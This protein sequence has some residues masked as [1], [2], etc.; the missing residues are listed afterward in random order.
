MKT[1]KVIIWSIVAIALLGGGYLAYTKLLKKNN[2]QGSDDLDKEP[3]PPS[4][5][6][7]ENPNFLAIKKNLG[8]GSAFP[9]GLTVKVKGGEFMF[10]IYNNNRFVMSRKGESGYL[11]KGT[12]SDGGTAL[13]VDSSYGGF[14]ASSGSVW[15]NM[16]SIVD[17]YNTKLAKDISKTQF[18]TGKI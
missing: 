17:Q 3:N 18:N 12:Y 15:Q 9:N 6:K 11:L 10:D 4:P 2:K 1:G 13:L 5:D 16:N 14:K 8:G 7:A